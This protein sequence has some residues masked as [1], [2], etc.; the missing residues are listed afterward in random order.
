MVLHTDRLVLEPCTQSHF[1]GLHAINADPE[2]MRFITGRAETREETHAVIERVQA[3]WRRFGYSWWSFIEPSTRVIVGLGC[4]QN[5]RRCGSE[6]DPECPLEIGWRLRRDSWGRGLATEA[7]RAM[8]DYAF[9]V[10]GAQELLAVCD[11]E[12]VAS[13]GVMKRLGMRYRGL[14]N[15]YTRPCATY[16]VSAAD[17]RTTRC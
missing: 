4:L 9:S 17:W 8:G 1:E 6:P 15:W 14:E 16:V 11:P 10:L 5:L 3:R 2:V 7:G 13:S 12:N